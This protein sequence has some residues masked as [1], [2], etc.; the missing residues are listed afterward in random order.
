VLFRS[1]K[2]L[3]YF[4]NTIQKTYTTQVTKKNDESYK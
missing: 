1:L 3:K 4:Y 2:Y